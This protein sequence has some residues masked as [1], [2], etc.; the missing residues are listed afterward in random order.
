MANHLRRRFYLAN[1]VFIFLLSF[2][3]VFLNC[4][5]GGGNTEFEP[6][7]ISV[8]NN[9]KTVASGVPEAYCTEECQRDPLG[10]EAITALHSH[11]D[12]DHNGNIDL[13]EIE[14][15]IHYE[16]HI[17][18]GEKVKRREQNI[19]H[20]AQL[21]SL[22]EMWN[23]WLKSPV[24][25]WSP[26]EVADWL[27][28]HVELPQY[29]KLFAGNRISGLFL[30]RLAMD[31]HNFL[32]GLGVNSMV[33]RKK[34]NLKAMDAVLFGAP[35]V[36]ALSICEE[37]CAKDRAGCNALAD[38][39]KHLDDDNDGSVDTS[40][41]TEFIRDELAEDVGNRQKSFLNNKTK[42]TAKDIWCTWV[43]SSVRQWT[44]VEVVDWLV[45]HVELPQYASIFE[46]NNIDGHMLAKIAADKLDSVGF[47]LKDHLGISSSK[48][49]QKIR[50]KAQDFVLFGPPK[51]KL[52]LQIL[53]ALAFFN[54][55]TNR[56]LVWFPWIPES[57]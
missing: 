57:S 27:T 55:C 28:I 48:D 18:N 10:F 16:L 38:L 50:I 5:V 4:M 44:V 35:R 30:P 8:S 32:Q 34:I 25:S 17:S 3:L 56:L 15:F 46:E 49:R 41:T 9:E 29:A 53:C 13:N 37:E 7:S 6:T 36:P 39:H 26:E 45:N 47:F 24:R 33:H 51:F 1:F 20:G 19:L 12:E 54:G 23:I 43:N 2:V 31:K 40:E 52:S 14:G 42:V 22:L 11:L 21:A